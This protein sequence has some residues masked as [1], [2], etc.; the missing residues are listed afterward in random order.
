MTVKLQHTYLDQTRK[1]EKGKASKITFSRKPLAEAEEKF[2]T[3]PIVVSLPSGKTI[4]NVRTA[5]RQLVNSNDYYLIT[6]K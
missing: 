6:G 2:N 4:E 3:N 5:I 1:K